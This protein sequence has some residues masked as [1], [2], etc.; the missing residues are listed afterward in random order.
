M[1]Y[2]VWVGGSEVTEKPVD[3]DTADEM[4]M[5]YRDEGYDYED[6]WIDEVITKDEPTVNDGEVPIQIYNR[7]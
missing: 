6:V 5:D 3:R 2:T 1:K 4:L 7:N